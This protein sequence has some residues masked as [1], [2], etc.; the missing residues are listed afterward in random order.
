MQLSA[1]D[2]LIGLVLGIWTT[3]IGYRLVPLSDDPL[4]NARI[5]DRFG[6]WFKILGPAIAVWSTV[7]IV[8]SF[9]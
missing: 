5:L 8:R 7:S 9:A 1:F 4:K 3:L 6:L 2:G